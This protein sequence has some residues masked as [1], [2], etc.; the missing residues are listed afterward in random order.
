MSEQIFTVLTRKYILVNI[1]Y[2]ES[3]FGSLSPE[4]FGEEIGKWHF[5]LT[6]D[7]VRSLSSLLWTDVAATDALS[8]CL[9]D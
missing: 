1:L 9:K 6:S 8:L 3:C 7:L 2:S 5:I 4:S